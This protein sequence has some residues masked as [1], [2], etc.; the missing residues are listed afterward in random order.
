MIHENNTV[1]NPW[2]S[3]KFTSLENNTYMEVSYL[4]NVCPMCF[5]HSVH[6]VIIKTIIDLIDGI[7]WVITTYSCCHYFQIW[8]STFILPSPSLCSTHPFPHYA[9]LKSVF[10]RKK[11]LKSSYCPLYVDY[12]V[13][14]KTARYRQVAIIMYRSTVGS[15]NICHTVFNY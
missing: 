1:K 3:A 4:C 9:G 14:C 2:P 10:T 7:N 13:Y 11:H 5:Q 8:F 12:S 6:T 15:C